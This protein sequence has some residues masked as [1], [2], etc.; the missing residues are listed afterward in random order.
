[1]EGEKRI[2]LVLDLVHR[3]E[4]ESS[5]LVNIHEANTHFSKLLQR[6][7]QGEE[8]IIARAG[9]PVARLSPVAGKLARRSPGTA[10]GRVIVSSDFDALLPDD[11]QKSF[12]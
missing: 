4:G 8:I 2:D 1:M 7:L 3:N 11:L 12:R 5:M 6:V 9:R 10:R